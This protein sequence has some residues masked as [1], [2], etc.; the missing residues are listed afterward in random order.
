MYR[1]EVI[2]ING[3]TTRF[4]GPRVRVARSPLAERDSYYA[5]CP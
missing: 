4:T 2:E 5:I 3:I 1:T